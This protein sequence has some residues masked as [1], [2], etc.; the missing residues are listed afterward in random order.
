M[1]CSPGQLNSSPRPGILRGK[2]P[3]DGNWKV[4]GQP[5]SLCSPGSPHRTKV[6]AASLKKAI[7]SPLSGEQPP[8]PEGSCPL[9]HVGVGGCRV[10]DFSASP[11]KKPRKQNVVANEDQ[12]ASNVP[13]TLQQLILQQQPETGGDPPQEKGASGSERPAG[14]GSKEVEIRYL[15][16][17]RQ[18]P[19]PIN[20]VYKLRHH[21]AHNHF[22]RYADIKLKS[23]LPISVYDLANDRSSQHRASG[24]KL[25][26]FNSQL[27][28]VDK[29]ETD[30]LELMEEVHES[31]EAVMQDSGCLL[32]SIALKTTKEL[33][34]GNIDRCNRVR[35]HVESTTADMFMVLDQRSQVVGV[36][37]K[38]SNF[39]SH[40]SSISPSLSSSSSSH[41]HKSQS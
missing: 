36:L 34:Q 11:R 28:E 31:L 33:I 14:G 41:H 25:F 16:Q 20:G 37:D 9:N 29:V 19:Y 40:Y 32:D 10:E 2:R 35:Y 5:N 39:K 15:S 26:H 12:Y 23:S 22:R 18:S 30:C 8:S 24:W 13:D 7:A 17:L 27:E 4:D 3:L 6:Q 21:V 38:Y 1:L